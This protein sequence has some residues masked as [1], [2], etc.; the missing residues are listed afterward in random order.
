[1][2]APV[3]DWALLVVDGIALIGVGAAIM[4]ASVARSRSQRPRSG[5]AEL[6]WRDVS[7]AGFTWAAAT[8]A[9]LLGSL[10]E[11]EG[12]QVPIWLTLAIVIGG[13]CLLIVRLRWVRPGLA[14]AR[15]CA[16]DPS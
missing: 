8:F 13:V 2:N 12:S 4:L 9:L 3:T 5:I 15:S 11:I 16:Y 7:Q 6:F 1:M 14:H 10:L